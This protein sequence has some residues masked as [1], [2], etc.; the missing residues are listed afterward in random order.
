MH[1]PSFQPKG[2]PISCLD[3]LCRP[4]RVRGRRYAR[5]NPITREDGALFRATLS[6]D[7]IINGFRN[8]DLQARLYANPARTNEERRRRSA[9]TS[10]QIR[11]LR[12][13]GLVAKV[14]GCRLYRVTNYG[15]QVMS[16]AIEYRDRVFPEGILKSSPRSQKRA[17]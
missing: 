17:A 14:P 10:R 6:G 9:R 11:K 5:F 4:R 12:G 2:E 3:R 7:H 15:N 13:H 8:R 1:S 16:A